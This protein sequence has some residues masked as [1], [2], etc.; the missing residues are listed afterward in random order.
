[1]LQKRNDIDINIE[2]LKSLEISVKIK[3]EFPLKSIGGKI[4][5]SIIYIVFVF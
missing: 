1:M 5:K 2:E 4:V 3:K